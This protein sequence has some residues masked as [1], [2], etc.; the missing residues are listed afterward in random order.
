[1]IC[2]LVEER[3]SAY[4][5]DMLAPDERRDVTIH[6]QSCSRCMTLL[7]ELRQNDILLAHLPRVAPSPALRERL[8]AT[9]EIRELLELLN[10]PGQ[11]VPTGGYG[12]HL[13][14]VSASQE[15]REGNGRLRLISPPAERM[16]APWSPLPM[17]E[18]SPIPLPARQRPEAPSV[19]RSPQPRLRKRLFTPLKIAIAAA[20][21]VA[22]GTAS[23]LG[24]S[25]RQQ[26]TSA[27]LPGAIT[28]PAGAA[29]GQ[30]VPLAAGSR[31]VFLRAGTL[32]STLADGGN[33]QPER[34]T[35][36][37]VT[38]AAGWVVNPAQGNHTAGDLLAYIDS[39]SAQVHTIRSDGQQDTPVRQALFKT[40]NAASWD[41]AEGRTILGSLAWSPDGSLLAF[42]GD[43]TGTGQTNLY[44]YSLATSTVRMVATNLKGSASS[45][46]WSPN[47]TRLAFTLTHAGAVDILDYNVRGKETLNLSNLAASQGTGANKVLALAWSAGTGAPAVT[48][49]L[50]TIGRISS[51]WLHRVGADSTTYPQRLVSGNYLQ[52]LYSPRVHAN[53]GGWLLVATAAGRASDIWYLELAPGA[54]L[55]PLS[56][57]KQV[58][59]ARWSPDGST[60]FY[61]DGQTNG[62]G[63]G[64]LVNMSSGADQPVSAQVAV[65]PA[66]AWS[67]D[68]QQLAYSTGTQI[69]IA[70]T[71]ISS[72]TLQL[73]LRGQFTDFSWSPISPHQLLVAMSTPTPGIYL[74]DTQHNS[75]QQLDRV[76]TTSDVQ[77][78][79]IP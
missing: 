69:T 57:G 2:E 41:S 71:R 59:F 27:N 29:S 25:F 66:P 78:T 14:P 13:T 33:R 49:S 67:A 47:S 16:P 43:P 1:M 39:Q 62:L 61:L 52:A 21:I 53:A 5:D 73:Q 15:A 60:I 40:A 70:S 56:Q 74:V 17:E 28:P 38:V 35:P 4:L 77:W 18:I 37:N 9:P 64:H 68:G 7:A 31:F 75:S 32:W 22:L 54:R 11:M 55:V 20:L 50:G 46:V 19:P 30:L 45:P 34:L 12:H 23:L 76:G 72:Q 36:A 65:N 58:S 63:I 6:L 26:T 3:L 24:L 48:W 42:A 10:S 44:L 51:I 8:F 79:E